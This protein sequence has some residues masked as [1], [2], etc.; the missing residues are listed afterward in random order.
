V[1]PS[2]RSA[3]FDARVGAVRFV[4]SLLRRRCSAGAPSR[5]APRGD[6]VRVVVAVV[7][8]RLR[9]VVS[10]SVRSLSATP[11]EDPP[12]GCRSPCSRPRGRCAYGRLRCLVGPAPPFAAFAGDPQRC[13]VV[14]NHRPE[15]DTASPCV[16]G[17]RRKP[18]ADDCRPSYRPPA[19]SRLSSHMTSGCRER[20]GPALSSVRG[21]CSSQ[22]YRSFPPVVPGVDELPP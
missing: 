10:V 11:G 22:S 8:R 15:G 21:P 9:V 6:C 18:E 13:E 14:P 17:G 2:G 5:P 7:G 3:P 4:A 16:T 20:K 12:P 19:P 1:P